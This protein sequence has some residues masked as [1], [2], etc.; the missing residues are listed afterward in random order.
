ME[1]MVQEFLFK[2]FKY[3]YINTYI[4]KYIYLNIYRAVFL[5]WINLPMKF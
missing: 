1:E 3:I 2:E 4:L 5:V